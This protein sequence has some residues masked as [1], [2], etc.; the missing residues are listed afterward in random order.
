M[1]AAHW[2]AGKTLKEHEEFTIPLN[3]SGDCFSA[4]D[5]FAVRTLTGCNGILISRGALHNPALFNDIKNSW[6]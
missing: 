3:M 5:A 6:G 4:W 1:G 2:I